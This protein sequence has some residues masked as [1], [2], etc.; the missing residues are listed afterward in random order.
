[1]TKIQ[2]VKVAGLR[3]KGQSLKGS[4]A[5]V[6]DD[7]DKVVISHPE[8]GNLVIPRANTDLPTT[9]PSAMS[10]EE[11]TENIRERFRVMDRL[12]K[13]MIDG[14]TRSIIISGAPG[15]GKSFGIDATLKI[16]QA[17]GL[18]RQ[19][20]FIKVTATPISFYQTL[21]ENRREGDI[22][23]LDDA[24]SILETEEGANMLKH[25]T[26]TLATRT[27]SYNKESSI[28]ADKGIPREFEYKGAIIA[29]TN[30]DWDR[31]I[32]SGSKMQKHYEALLDRAIYLDL[33]LHSKQALMARVEDVCRTTPMLKDRGLDDQQIEMLLGWLKDNYVAT[34]TLSLR[35]AVQLAGMILSQPTEWKF[36]A[37]M[38]LLTAKSR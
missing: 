30:K 8:F 38:T 33:G 19:V 7:G 11:L 31:E 14:T 34:R 1:M 13:G 32:A 26:D 29:A 5:L 15:V 4:Y 35:T 21:Y 3:C 16:A 2:N 27:V 22:I 9:N 10:Y 23:V 25:A 20:K 12:L 18:V 28:L 37:K 17:H 36:D 24:D 6:R